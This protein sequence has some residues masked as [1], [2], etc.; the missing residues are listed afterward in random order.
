MKHSID[1]FKYR[2]TSNSGQKWI[3]RSVDLVSFSSDSG[4]TGWVWMDYSV[5]A[6]KHNQTLPEILRDKVCNYWGSG[7]VGSSRPKPTRVK[8]G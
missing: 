2:T 1:E 8:S 5:H 7:T 6:V 3:E 4:D